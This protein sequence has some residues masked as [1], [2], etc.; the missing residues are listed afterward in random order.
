[1]STKMS[2]KIG[3]FCQLRNATEWKRIK[4]I[5]FVFVFEHTHQE[6]S[7]F[8]K[9]SKTFSMMHKHF[10]PTRWKQEKYKHFWW[11]AFHFIR[12]CYEIVS[13][14]LRKKKNNNMLARRWSL[15]VRVV[16]FRPRSCILAATLWACLAF[17]PL[18][19]T[20]IQLTVGKSEIPTL[21][22]L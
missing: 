6:V 2:R 9:N 11:Y 7:N 19:S 20:A 22:S 4:I 1:M 15:I 13:H 16:F 8:H 17:Q 5:N 14:S 21:I 10:N 12:N 18:Q 3:Q